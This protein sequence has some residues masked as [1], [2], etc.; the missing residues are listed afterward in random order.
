MTETIKALITA[1][2]KGMNGKGVQVQ[3]W[4]L[5]FFIGWHAQADEWEIYLDIT[6]NPVITANTQ[7]IHLGEWREDGDGELNTLFIMAFFVG[8]AELF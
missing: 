7:D 2:M 3:K 5:L 4:C 1:V 8:D 6:A